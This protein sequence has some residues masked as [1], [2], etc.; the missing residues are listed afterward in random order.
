MFCTS[1][2]M[3]RRQFRAWLRSLGVPA[4]ELKGGRYVEHTTFALCL[5]ASF[6]CTAPLLHPTP[7]SP[8]RSARRAPVPPPI[9]ADLV[10]VLISQLT[11]ASHTSDRMSRSAVLRAAKRAAAE[12]A[13][14]GY[15]AEA[16]TARRDALARER[17]AKDP[18]LQPLLASYDNPAATDTPA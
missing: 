10:P 6:R 7:G 17:A 8:S 9:T 11:L 4:L 18:L 15:T 5:L 1:L 3:T 14:A 16:H 12:L 2:H 13:L